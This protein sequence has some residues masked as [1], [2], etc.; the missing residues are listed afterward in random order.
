MKIAIFGTGGVGGYYGGLLSLHGQ[1]VSFL[2]RREHLQA[3][4]RDGLQVKSVHG[5]FTVKPARATE[6]PAEV[7]PVDLVLICTKTY[8]MEAVLR[9]LPALVG[10]QTA[11]ISLQNG[12]DAAERVGKAVGLQHVLGGA[13]WLSA[14]VGSPGVIRQVSQFRRVVIGE[15]DGSVTPRVQAVADAFL[16]TGVTIEVSQTISKVIWMKFVFISAASGVGGLT[17]LP[18]GDYRHV[19][20]TRALFTG[21]MR[22][23]EALA[24]LEG[25]LL[26][27]DL[28]E[29]TLAFLDRSD[30]QIKPSMQRDIENGNMF[31][32]EALIGAIG[33]KAR[34][35]HLS[36]PIV[37]MVYASLLPVLLSSGK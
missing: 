20:Q 16:P 21:L 37:D 6:F 18:L 3:I 28:I 36:T 11:I 8:S 9:D 14:A 33:R 29:Q 35:R 2:A 31:E 22:E 15:L 5:D 4:L 12:I 19:P 7:G 26:D 23:V 27:S 25:I 30:P 1:E 13:T 17:R 10:P 34:E 32:L 24:A